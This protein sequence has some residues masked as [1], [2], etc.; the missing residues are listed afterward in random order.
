M[1]SRGYCVRSR[2]AT[3]MP[4]SVCVGGIR[5][6]TTTA[7]RS[8]FVTTTR[9]SASPSSAVATTVCPAST[10]SRARPSRT[11]IESSAIATLQ[12]RHGASATGM[13]AVTVV[14]RPGCASTVS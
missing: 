1:P 5:M 8:G 3:A 9:T 12:R 6:S 13:R 7:S 4:S 2:R 14:P 11:I 10:R